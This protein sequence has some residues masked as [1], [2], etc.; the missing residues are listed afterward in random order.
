[1]GRVEIGLPDF[2]NVIQSYDCEKW[3]T[4]RDHEQ[5]VSPE[6]VKNYFDLLEKI[7]TENGLTHNPRQIYNANETFL[8]LNETKEKAV[9]IKNKCVCSQYLG[10]TEHIAMLCAGS[11]SGSALPPM[12]IYPKSFP[13]GQYKFGGPDDALYGKSES[14]WVDSKLFLEWMKQIF[15]RYAVQERPV[16][17]IIDGHK[18][19]LTLECIDLARENQV[20][21]LCLP[22]HTT[23]ALQP[24]DVAVFKALK[25]HFSRS[26]R[27]RCF[28]K[29]NFIVSKCDFARVVKE[30]F[31]FSFLM[32]NLKN[33]FSKCGIFPF[34]RTAVSSD[35]MAPS[36]VYQNNLNTPSKDQVEAAHSSTDE[37]ALEEN[38]ALSITSEPSSQCNTTIPIASTLCAQVSNMQSSQES[39]D[40]K[41]VLVLDSHYSQRQPSLTMRGY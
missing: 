29:K 14:G 39:K 37:L 22:P 21:L 28:S 32:A 10:T 17:L 34:N 4:W 19:H 35:K 36:S 23:H 41:L 3:I 12:I 7:L 16:L 30:L 27:V 1:M 25:A 8:P 24:L 9:T 40:L 5:N 33:G 38:A 15:L 20:I 6:V 18:S 2:V 11:A 13:G 31:E 26:L